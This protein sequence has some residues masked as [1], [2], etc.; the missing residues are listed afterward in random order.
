MIK[1][2][3]DRA[4]E[5]PTKCPYCEH[6]EWSEARINGPHVSVQCRNCG[7]WIHAKQ[8]SKKNWAQFIKQRADWKCERCGKVVRGRAAHAHHKLPVHLFPDR[9]FDLDNGICLCTECHNLI[10]GAFGTIKEES[11]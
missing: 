9:E 5:E 6:D 8:A 4:Y 11:K 7:G 3:D 10:H 2:L 1:W